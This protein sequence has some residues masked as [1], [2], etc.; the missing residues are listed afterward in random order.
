MTDP[1]RYDDA[2]YVLGA[3]D[4]A[5]RVAFEAHLET[6]AECR[7][8]VADA[9]AGHDLLAGL[10]AHDLEDVAPMP[11]TLLPGLLRSARRERI[12][13]R[14]LMASLAAV[15]AAC[16]AALIVVLWPTGS[17][18]SGPAARQFEALRPSPVTATA[19]LVA[20]GW[21]TQINLQCRYAYSVEHNIPYLLAIFD[22]SG[23]KYL[24]GSWT[25]APGE[26]T[27][28]T[29][30]T[31]VQLPDIARV[32]ISLPNGTPVLQLQA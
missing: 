3:L 13:R 24:A 14:G 20:K 9:R 7:A 17:G 29:G 19:T 8:R 21:G 16:A 28:F 18:P 23:R 32:V 10:D 2:V 15:A 30:G 11:D 31:A 1:F 6:C 4:T 22:K 25:L 26:E 27:K 5:E 12:R